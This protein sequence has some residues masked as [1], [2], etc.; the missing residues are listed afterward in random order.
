MTQSLG[1]AGK[2]EFYDNKQTKQKS[3][4]KGFVLKKP[5]QSNHLTMQSGKRSAK[6]ENEEGQSIGKHARWVGGACMWQRVE[7]VCWEAW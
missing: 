6:R 5:C 1:N 7:N 3:L 2:I 4:S